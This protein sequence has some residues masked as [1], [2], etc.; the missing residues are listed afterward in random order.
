MIGDGTRD[1]PHTGCHLSIQARP[2]SLT[3]P[4]LNS[5]NSLQPYSWTVS[6]RRAK[7]GM[8][9]FSQALMRQPEVAPP[10]CAPLR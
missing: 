1:G 4:V 6:A 10:G 5:R 7:D 9:S 8:W 3:P 2:T